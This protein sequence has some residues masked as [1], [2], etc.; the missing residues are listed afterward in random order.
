MKT[1][2]I[3]CWMATEHKRGRA[4]IN[5]FFR[6]GESSLCERSRREFA[7]SDALKI[8]DDDAFN[9]ARC[10]MRKRQHNELDK[11]GKT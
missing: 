4:K 5:H 1:D 6:S 8:S 10:Q 11:L 7:T 2:T 9:C 3:G